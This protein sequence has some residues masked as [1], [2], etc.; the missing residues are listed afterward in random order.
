MT[1]IPRHLLPQIPK[2]KIQEFQKFLESKG[3]KSRRTR[4]PVT[5]FL[6][7][8]KHVNQEKVDSLMN[9]PDKISV[10]PNIATS[11]GYLVDGH[12]R[13]VAARKLKMEDLDSVVCDCNLKDFLKVAHQFDHTYVKSVHELTTY[14][15]LGLVMESRMTSLTEQTE[16]K[17][18]EYVR[19]VLRSRLSERSSTDENPCWNGYQMIG[20]KTKNG[21]QVPNCVPKND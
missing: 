12:H 16:Q 3:I 15:R 18:R 20:K 11:E 8:Q 4:M 6:P 10:S 21:R 17:L 1:Q 7:I 5:W 14:G 13:W 19:N 2:D 9:E